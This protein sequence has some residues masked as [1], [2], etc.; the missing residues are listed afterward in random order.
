VWQGLRRREALESEMVAEFEHHIEMRTADLVRAGLA[1]ADAARQAR[2][3]F[4]HVEGHRIDARASR[5]LAR[6]DQLR[7]SALD[8]RLGVRMLAKYPALSLVSVLGM[9]LAIAIVAT[10]FSIF[11]SM[12]VTGL[13]LPEG[14]R[15]VALRNANIASPGQHQAMLGDFMMW[16]DE[17][18]SVDDLAAFIPTS[19]TLVV[20]GGDAPAEL[21]RVVWMTP[22]G[23]RLA[24]TAAVRGRVL[25]DEDER[26][27]ARVVVI[28]YDEWQGRFAADPSIVGRR[29][30]LGGDVYT[31]VGVM[32][33][34]FRFPVDDRYWIPLESRATERE[35]AM[36]IPVTVVGRLKDG[37][38]LEQAQA[39]LATIGTRLAAAYPET[40]A[41]LRPR[42]L[43]YT[44][45]FF[46]I[47]GPE[48]VWTVQLFRFFVSLLLVV[49]A[50]NV[51]VLI[52]A[53][54]AAR[55]GEIA[56]RT[57]LGASRSRVVTQLFAE[58][59]ALSAT[60]AVIGLAIAEV[61]L[62]KLQPLAERRMG[63]MPFW[64]DLTVSPTVIA[65]AVL[66]AIVGAA[67]AGVAPALKAT[68]SRVLISLQQLSGG[69]ATRMQLG[70]GWT[71]LIVGQV[72]VAVAV[73]PFAMAFTQ[74]AI[75]DAAA[76]GG[77]AVEQFLQAT[78][79]IE[80]ADAPRDTTVERLVTQRFATRA[81]ELLRRL[82][83]DPAIAGVTIRSTGSYDDRVEIED[84]GSPGATTQRVRPGTDRVDPDFFRLYDMPILAGRSFD[85]NDAR[86]GATAVVVNQVFV[87]EHFAGSTV[88]GRRVRV[89]HES[90][91]AGEAEAGP[92]LEIVGVVR[93]LESNDFEPQDNIYL[94]LDVAQL[95]PPLRLAIRVRAGTPIAFAPRL[96]NVAAA[97]DPQLQL[98]DVIT[99]VER[100]RL[101]RQPARY[102]AI[103][104]TVVMLSVLL[105][106]AAGI[107]AMMSFTVA[108]RRR[109]IGIRSALG[110][111]SRRLLGS[112]FARASTQIAIG[113]L[114]GMVGTFAVDRVAGR[115]PVHDGNA[116]MVP[117]VAV[118]MAVVG[119]MAAI[120]PARRGLAIHPTEA[121]RAE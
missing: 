21:V 102:L 34:G 86:A 19:R 64:I 60:A 116:I 114:I 2:L 30:E 71:A 27:G 15:V 88:L 109:E 44:R 61:A 16:R 115:G 55:S 77:Y 89:V 14:E 73:L 32:P 39:D 56:V 94:P 68:G 1:P 69:G 120:G 70:R 117:V 107:Y 82:R 37:T 31:I 11:E 13:P 20:P 118:L 8:L 84:I 36:Q 18:S 9:A 90:D 93:D 40:H 75:G 113:I 111:D 101:G 47:D 54:T 74:E 6:L 53:R 33:D 35:R 79:A 59:L 29:I 4:G 87:E 58:A 7:F 121:L 96:R 49:V 66:L 51:A 105:L 42:V 12:L 50:V 83:S 106:S 103:A 43:P 28:G 81:A 80:D 22:S 24:R 98:T 97:V 72:A 52:Y 41:R 112:V 10:V 17:A 110:A 85:S 5:G 57:A 67:I 45:A 76:G 48:T 23:F 100:E 78:L 26:G 65:Y 91:G 119:L 25:L 95:S 63:E 104:T 99:G 3:E 108:R 92:W 38:T 46:D 62:R